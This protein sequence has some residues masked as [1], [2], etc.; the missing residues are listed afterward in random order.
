MNPDDS[1]ST[2]K[3]TRT[4]VAGAGLSGLTV[5][6]ALAS[7]GRDVLVIEQGEHAGGFIGSQR[8]S[9][10]LMERG[11]NT[12]VGPDPVAESLVAELGLESQKVG[13]GEQVRHRY[14]VR[15]GIPRALALAPARFFASNFFTLPGRLRLLLEP[16]VTARDGDESIAAFTRRR[17]GA[18]MLD[19]VMDPLVGGLY[20]GD[21]RSL[22]V[23]AV[24]PRLK[25]FERR[26]GSVIKG[27]LRAR[28]RR[29]SALAM[30]PANRALFS[31]H[32]G[33]E[34]LPQALARALGR[35]IVYG[36]RVEA[37]R[38]VAGGYRV[39]VRNGNE[40]RHLAANSVV[41]SLPAHA[42]AEIV[43]PLDDRAGAALAHIPH[44]PLGVVFFGYRR[45]DIAHPLDGLGVLT[46]A[47][48]Q[49]KTLGILFSSTLF[50]GRAPADHV[51]LTVFIG[52]QRQP[53]LARLGRDDLVALARDEVRDLL[54]AAA[55]PVLS[56]IH[57]WPRALPQPAPRHAERIQHLRDFENRYLGFFLTGNYLAGVSTT[58]CI[59]QADLVARRAMDHRAWGRAEKRGAAA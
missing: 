3:M 5:A 35:H 52:G 16:F 46:P 31:F 56:R 29:G 43:A 28:R 51:A 54:G 6:H 10:F 30:H 7:A 2:G 55:E 13:R 21:P 24:F 59:A 49:R 53:E 1:G 57:V 39:R 40:T 18:E 12:M 17:F 25:E 4:I 44:P 20:A 32:Q 48:E 23:D 36:S 11:P 19:Y 22:S 8:D 27:L 14:L 38:P 26:Y 47:I 9:G 58:A 15:D 42:A 33:M 41:L 50:P 34:T 45:R 37:I